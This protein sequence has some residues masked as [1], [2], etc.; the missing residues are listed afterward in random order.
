M[1]YYLQLKLVRLKY[2]WERD[3]ILRGRTATN[4]WFSLHSGTV[5]NGSEVI[6]TVHQIDH[7]FGAT[8]PGTYLNRQQIVSNYNFMLRYWFFSSRRNLWQGTSPICP[9]FPWTK[10]LLSHRFPLPAPLL[11]WVGQSPLSG[12]VHTRSQPNGDLPREQWLPCRGS[13]PTSAALLLQGKRLL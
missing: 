10:F 3:H 6:P 2:W 8:R 7:A 4:F 12:W 11:S 5:F 9:Q 13:H 1:L